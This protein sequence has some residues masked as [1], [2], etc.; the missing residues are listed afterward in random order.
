MPV[1][2][3]TIKSLTELVDS[4]DSLIKQLEAEAKAE[5]E[6]GK[7]NERWK[8]KIGED[9]FILN[10]DGEINKWRYISHSSDDYAYQTGNCFKTQK[11]AELHKLRLESM[12]NRW[13]PEKGEKF[14]YYCG[15]AV[16]IRPYKHTCDYES[17]WI[18]NCHKTEEDARKWCKKYGEAFG[19]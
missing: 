12:A 16:Q 4:L 5:D 9:Y 13:R 19:I 14:Y 7:S 3:Q 1:N 11:E 8:P 6:S 10:R 17:Y 2:E 15:S 18:G